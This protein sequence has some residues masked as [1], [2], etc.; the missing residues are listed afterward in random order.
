QALVQIGSAAAGNSPQAVTVN[1]HVIPPV[2]FWEP[3]SYYDGNLTTMGNLN[4]SGS[5]TSEIQAQNG[6][7][8]IMGGA[9]LFSAAHAVNCAGSNGLIGVEAKIRKGVGTG[10]FFW[11]IAIDDTMS[12]NLA[13]WYG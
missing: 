12:N 9:G 4:W 8:K 2:C 1:L 5:A 10:D 11:N 3:F 6:T 7:L 13:R